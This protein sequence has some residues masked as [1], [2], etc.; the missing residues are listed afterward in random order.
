MLVITKACCQ[1]RCSCALVL[2]WGW[3]FAQGALDGVL[4][5]RL[6]GKEDSNPASNFHAHHTHPAPSSSYITDGHATSLHDPSSFSS[7]PWDWSLKTQTKFHSDTSFEWT[8]K[9]TRGAVRSAA[10]ASVASAAS[11]KRILLILRIPCLLFILVWTFSTEHFL[12][13]VAR[14]P[15]VTLCSGLQSINTCCNPH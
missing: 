9:A 10:I 14:G 1:M 12:S 3:M 5:V 7:L 2:G 15:V 8:A 4:R 6:Q 13:V 11:R